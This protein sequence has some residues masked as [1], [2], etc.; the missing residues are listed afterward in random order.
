MSDIL[1]S[2]VY[3]PAPISQENRVLLYTS[4]GASPEALQ[5]TM[6]PFALLLGYLKI[7]HYPGNLKR[8]HSSNPLFLCC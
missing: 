2:L 6:F 1:C 5:G 7:A 3:F 8:G 4:L